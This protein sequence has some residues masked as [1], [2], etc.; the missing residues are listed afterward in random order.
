MGAVTMPDCLATTSE[1]TRLL[2]GLESRLQ[3]LLDS[4]TARL[5]WLR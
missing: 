1:S 3:D 2:A 5:Q 4:A